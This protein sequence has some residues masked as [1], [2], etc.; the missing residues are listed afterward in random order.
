MLEVEYSN[1][2]PYIK[3][4]SAFM[5]GFMIQNVLR[6]STLNALACKP[7]DPRTNSIHEIWA[8]YGKDFNYIISISK[9][10]FTIV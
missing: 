4:I 10:L 7:K 3:R 8:E 6:P 9:Y 2:Y 5:N 1:D